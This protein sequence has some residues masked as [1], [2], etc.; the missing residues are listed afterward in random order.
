MHKPFNETARVIG[1]TADAGGGWWVLES[2]DKQSMSDED[3]A[4]ARRALN[5]VRD[6]RRSAWAL[7]AAGYR[8]AR[9][10][11]ECKAWCVSTTAWLLPG[12][13]R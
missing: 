2:G 1:L 11:R 4:A 7:E 6:A 13:R 9:C 3:L 5:L 12:A 10:W 8:L